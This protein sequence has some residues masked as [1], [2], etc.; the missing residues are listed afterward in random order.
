MAK[1]PEPPSYAEPVVP[2]VVRT[3]DGELTG[4]GEPRSAEDVAPLVVRKPDGDQT[5]E[6]DRVA[7][8]ADR[9]TGSD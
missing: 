6:A 2:L 7:K 8:I 9:L 3:P 5:A 4:E 1:T